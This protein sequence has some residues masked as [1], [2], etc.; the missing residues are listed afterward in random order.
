MDIKYLID[1][2]AHASV[3]FTDVFTNKMEPGQIDIGR[4]TAPGKCG[5]VV[6]LA[7]SAIFSFNGV[8][9]AMEPGMVVH[10]G[11]QMPIEIK[12]L[13]D[14]GWEYAVV[15]YHIPSEEIPQYPLSAQHFLINTGYHIKIIDYV[16]Q[17][18]ESQAM[19]D[20]MSIFKAKTLFMNLLEAILISAKVKILDMASDQMEQALQYIHENY[21]TQLSVSKIA[22]EFGVERRRFAYLFEQHTGMTPS[23]YL[24]EYRIRRSKELLKYDDSPVAEI[25]ECVGYVDCFYFSRVFKKCTGMSPTTYRKTMLGEAKYV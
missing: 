25:A 18:I 10:A 17:L 20:N 6:P 4:T 21:A 2:Y 16:Q 11:P 5:L 15:H 1:Y 7:G 13:D 8:P 9:Y 24:T 3:S 23:V 14:K 22:E 12:A 19:P